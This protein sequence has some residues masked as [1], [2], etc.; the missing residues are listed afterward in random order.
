MEGGVAVSEQQPGLRF[1]I[2]ERVHL[3]EEV[4]A[5]QELDEVELTPQIRVS[6]E[7][8]QAVVKG[9]LLLVG[10]YTGQADGGNRESQRLEHTIPVEITLPINRISSVDDIAVEIENFDIDLL[11]PRS[12]NVTGVLTLNG[13][14]MLSGHP[15]VWRE[16]EV[17]FVHEPLKPDESH[18]TLVKTESVEPKAIEPKA[19]G[20]KATEPKT[21]EPKTTEPKTF[22]PKSTEPKS[23]EPKS[24]KPTPEA[25]EEPEAAP[26]E[27]EPKRESGGAQPTADPAAAAKTGEPNRDQLPDGNLDDFEA[28]AQYEEAPAKAPEAADGEAA[29]AAEAAE[30]VVAEEAEKGEMKIA[31]GSKK[32]EGAQP[33]DLKSHLGKTDDYRPNAPSASSASPASPEPVA[34]GIPRQGRALRGEPAPQPQPEP[35]AETAGSDVL[36][37]KNL[38]LSANEEQ[39][40]RTLR[41]CI[42]HKDD[43]VESI[44]KKYD[45]KPQEI[46]L[47]NSLNDSEL[48][49]GQVI[50]IP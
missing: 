45:R 26:L 30:T 11:S 25:A 24:L 28:L 29:E 1:D 6:V 43:T 10:A 23:F 14:E 22:E 31:F 34:Y 41:L 36:E 3:P 13:I 35:V 15:D 49:E 48:A 27:L 37:W 44:A 21:T 19:I 50:Y 9:C 5:I 39:Q 7:E 2:Y 47:H 18:P 4:S 17:L 40:F 16:E 32:Q 38:F 46:R 12:L 20:P 8:D 42:V 33:F